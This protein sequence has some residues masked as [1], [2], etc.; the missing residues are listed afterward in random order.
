MALGRKPIEI[1]NEGKH[2]LLVKADHWQRIYLREI[3][4]IQNGF[5]F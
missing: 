5:D 3:A 2:Q 4:K 1:V